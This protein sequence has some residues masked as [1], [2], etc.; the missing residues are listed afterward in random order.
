MKTNVPIRVTMTT[1][2]EP[3]LRK[4]RDFGKVV[5]RKVHHP[6]I[7]TET[8]F[9]QFSEWYANRQMMT[10]STKNVQS[11]VDPVMRERLRI[12]KI[13]IQKTFLITVVIMATAIALVILVCTLYIQVIRKE[14][15]RRNELMHLMY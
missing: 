11:T 5:P 1:T 3:S 7:N 9:E 6:K 10:T 8:D 12:R 15:K 4:V 2:L 13:A 14:W